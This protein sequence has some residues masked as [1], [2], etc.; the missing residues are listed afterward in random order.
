MTKAG[1]PHLL[2]AARVDDGGD[3]IDSNGCFCNVSRDDNLVDALPHAL[4]H[5]AL[6]HKH[7]SLAKHPQHYDEWVLE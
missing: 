4:K 5:L 3:I 1:V 7:S 2:D 6:H